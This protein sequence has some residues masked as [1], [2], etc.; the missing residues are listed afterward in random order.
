MDIQTFLVNFVSF[1]NNVVIPFL[2][3]IAFLFFIVNAF[4]YFILG[5]TSEDGKE[6]ARAL[7]LYS[8]LAFVFILVFWGL[9]NMFAG[10]LGL[11]GRGLPS[12]IPRSDYMLPDGYYDLPDCTGGGPC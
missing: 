12:D 6:K 4:R 9:V 10:S 8:V 1:A 5:G 7:A 2:I 11:A 3:G